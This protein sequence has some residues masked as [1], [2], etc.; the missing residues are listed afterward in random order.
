MLWI[1]LGYFPRRD[2]IAG[3][4]DTDDA[5]Q[6]SLAIA[7]SNRYQ[8]DRFNILI[9]HVENYINNFG[10]SEKSTLDSI[11][12]IRTGYASHVSHMKS[13]G[14]GHNRQTAR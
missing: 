1:S 7:L 12:G 8:M 9:T 14:C 13:N 10:N 6:L 5:N 3:L 4:A 11:T 2:S